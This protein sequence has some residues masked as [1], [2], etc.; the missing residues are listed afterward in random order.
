VTE[1]GLRILTGDELRAAE[2]DEARAAAAR[3]A[4]GAPDPFLPIGPTVVSFSGGRTSGYLLRRVLDA[5]GGSLPDHCKVIFCN[6]GREMPATL[7]FVAECG[8]RWGV[9]IVWLEY[10]FDE[11]ARRTGI[12]VVSHN[13]ASRNGEPFAALIRTKRYLPNPVTRYC[14]QEL[15]IRTAARYLRDVVGWKHWRSFVGL[16]S[17][18]PGRVLRAQ[19]RN[20]A[21]KTREIVECPL[22]VAGV[23]KASVLAWWASQAFDLRIRGP[24]AG[25][26][27][28]CFLKGRAALSLMFAEEPVRMAWWAEQEAAATAAF[29]KG[30][31]VYFRNDREPYA[32]QA[33]A[34]LAQGV[35]PLNPFEPDLGCSEWACTD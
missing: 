16:R 2:A 26:C 5:C 28:G 8:A 1:Q 18:E 34:T 14:T 21:R 20:A 33:A 13:S 24:H 12:E 30:S 22:A 7:D 9:S 32:K 3:A 4:P 15:K 11:E 35:L 29:G 27:D 17:D 31:G 6:T 19:R 10:R 25:N 23:D